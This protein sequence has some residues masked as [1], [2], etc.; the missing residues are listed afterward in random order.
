LLVLDF[1]ERRSVIK[2]NNEI[3]KNK[4]KKDYGCE[5]S[6][7]LDFNPRNEHIEKSE[8]KGKTCYIKVE[9]N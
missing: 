8:Y 5:K 7:L 2:Q 4:I 3:E 1:L 6:E 9:N